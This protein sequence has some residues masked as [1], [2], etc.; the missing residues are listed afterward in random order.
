VARALVLQNQPL[1]EWFGLGVFAFDVHHPVVRVWPR[2]GT[3]PETLHD[4]FHRQLQPL[5]LQASGWQALHAA[6]VVAS[7]TALLICGRAES[8]KSTLAYALAL[9]GLPQLADDQVVW[10]AAE[11]MFQ[12]RWLPFTPRLRAPSA[13][14]FGNARPAVAPG[15][16]ENVLLGRIVLLRPDPGW[17]SHPQLEPITP[18]RAFSRLLGYAHCFNPGDRAEASRLVRD[19]SEL[20]SRLPVFNLSFR[21]GLDGLDLVLDVLEQ[22]S[23]VGSRTGD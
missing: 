6:A 2:P 21:P 17:T 18:R 8:G 9:R 20:V 14:Y 23:A 16:A 12:A 19:Y 7:G 5:I 11:R 13:Q 3:A 4:V 10:R 15:S 1:I 22:A